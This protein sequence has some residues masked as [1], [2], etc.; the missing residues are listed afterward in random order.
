MPMLH[1]RRKWTA[2]SQHRHFFRRRG[3]ERQYFKKCMGRKTD[4]QECILALCGALHGLAAE[5]GLQNRIGIGSVPSLAC[6][7][8]FHTII[9]RGN[10]R[11]YRSATMRMMGSIWICLILVLVD[12][13]A[14]VALRY[15]L[16]AFTTLNFRAMYTLQT[17][18]ATNCSGGACWGGQ[19]KTHQ[20]S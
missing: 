7:I 19:I 1:V 13:D 4:A 20:A 3:G 8:G 10:W 6:L 18:I 16:S 15:A 2:S 9:T 12:S 11:C 14:P 5:R 17:Q